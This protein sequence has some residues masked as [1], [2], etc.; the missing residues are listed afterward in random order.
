MAHTSARTCNEMKTSGYFCAYIFAPRTTYVYTRIRE[1]IKTPRNPD[2]YYAILYSLPSCFHTR[3][4]ISAV[5]KDY[6]HLIV[7]TLGGLMSSLDW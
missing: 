7:F 4:R 2:E 6:L 1:R 5:E 3:S